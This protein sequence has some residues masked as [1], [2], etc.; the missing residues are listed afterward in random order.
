MNIL[1]QNQMPQKLTSAAKVKIRCFAVF[2]HRFDITSSE[3][4]NNRQNRLGL[5]YDQTVTKQ[6]TFRW[7]E[8]VNHQQTIIL[9]QA[10]SLATEKLIL[11][12]LQSKSDSYSLQLQSRSTQSAYFKIKRKL[13][14]D[15]YMLWYNIATRGTKTS[16]I[17]ITRQQPVVYKIYTKLLGYCQNIM[18][19]R[20]AKL[21]GY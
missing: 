2:T 3:S 13:W 9:N 18:L 1:E 21:L 16:Y 4:F 19:L 6:V 7:Q 12:Q 11:S 5:K 15:S 20:L 10:H 14:R 8:L 17:L